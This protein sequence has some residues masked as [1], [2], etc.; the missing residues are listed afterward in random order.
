MG[1]SRSYGRNRFVLNLPADEEQKEN[2]S[3]VYMP[4]KREE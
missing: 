3:T 1:F 4:T 2:S